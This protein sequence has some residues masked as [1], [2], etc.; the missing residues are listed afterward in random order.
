M[1][2]AMQKGLDILITAAEIQKRVEEMA[3]QIEADY[4]G[5]HLVVVGVLKGAFIFM[6]DLVR[7][8]NLPLRCDFLRVASYDKDQS[9]GVVRLEFDMT[10]PVAGKD[11]LLIEDIVDTGNTL[12]TLLKHLEGKKPS[13]LK[14][15]SLLYKE[16]GNE[17]R[18]RIDYLGFTIPTRYVI[19]FGLDSEGIYR[20]LPYVAAFR[21]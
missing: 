17:V 15:C 19:G 21:K 8:I 4:R 14:V 10:Q 2:P 9:T 11:V 13:S 3:R 12:R 1:S 7:H 16:V 6:A 5:K 20:S 18:K